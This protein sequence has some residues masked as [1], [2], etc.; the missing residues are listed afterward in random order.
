MVCTPITEGLD[1]RDSP[2]ASSATNMTRNAAPV[3]AHYAS[4]QI[5]VLPLR[6]NHLAASGSTH[7]REPDEQARIGPDFDHLVRT[8]RC[9][10]ERECGAQLLGE[11]VFGGE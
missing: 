2:R 1:P 6:G 10:D 8:F 3:Q 4:R 9:G 5:D 7:R 11:W